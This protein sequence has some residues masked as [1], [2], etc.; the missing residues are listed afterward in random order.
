MVQ[1]TAQY[2]ET[3]ISLNT[4]GHAGPSDLSP[5]LV[6]ELKS[7][8]KQKELKSPPQSNIFLIVEMPV[9]AMEVQ[10]MAPINGS[11]EFHKKELEFLTNLLNHTSPVPV[12]LKK[13]FAKKLILPAHQQMLPEPAEAFHKK[14]D[15][16]SD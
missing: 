12:T 14:V 4:A 8:E 3:N 16:V 15:L 6:I 2:Q 5:P 7:Q 1:A 10:S 11:I 9:L 13:D